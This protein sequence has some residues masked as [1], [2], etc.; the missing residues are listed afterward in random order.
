MATAE[1]ATALGVP[2]TVV[3]A[4]LRALGIRREPLW[5]AVRSRAG[6]V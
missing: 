1:L 6:D 3:L 4:D 2:E 5:R